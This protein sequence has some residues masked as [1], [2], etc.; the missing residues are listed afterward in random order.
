M[1]KIYK[2]LFLKNQIDRINIKKNKNILSKN[3]LTKLTL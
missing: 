3:I 2:Y 1:R